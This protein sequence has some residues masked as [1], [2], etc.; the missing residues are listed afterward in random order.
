MFRGEA[1]RGSLPKTPLAQ[2]V[3][4][5]LKREAAVEAE[6]KAKTAVRRRD[7]C[8]RMP[9]CGC[10]RFNLALAVCHTRHKGAGGN[11]AGDRSGSADMIY[12]CAARHRENIVSL[13]RGTLRIV[14]LTARRFAGPCRWDV[15]LRAVTGKL[16]SKPIW[17]TVGV[18][19]RIGIFEA[20]TPDQRELLEQL[21]KMTR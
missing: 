1:F 21:R 13:D 3:V 2:K 14:P 8:C 12:L 11:P 7:K 17:T 20:F 9:L 6:D 16:S 4:R 10:R 18:E 5:G 15:D 19:V